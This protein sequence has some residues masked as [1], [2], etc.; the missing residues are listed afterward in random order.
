MFADKMVI[1][2]T[3]LLE[4]LLLPLPSSSLEQA[5]INKTESK[6]SFFIG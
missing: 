1:L 6:S 2:S 4:L 3:N 5:K